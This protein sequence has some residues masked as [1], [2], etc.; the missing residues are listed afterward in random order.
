MTHGISSE[1]LKILY[2]HRTQ[3]RGAEGNHIVSIVTGIRELGHQVDILSPPGVDPFDSQSTIPADQGSGVERGWSRFWKVISSKLPAPLFEL[4]EI[5]YN[6]PAYFRLRTALRRKDYDLLYERYAT[7]L[8][9]GGLAARGAGCRLLL[10]I[11]G[12]TVV[13]DRNRAQRFSRLCRYVE[14][15]VLGKCDCAHV[16]SSYLAE[17]VVKSGFS[18]QRLVVVPN[19]FDVNRI[20]INES[21][22]SMRERFKFQDCIVVGFAGWFVP[23]DRLDLLFDVFGQLYQRNKNLRL[24]L[25]GEGE[26]ARDIMSSEKFSHLDDSIVITGAVPRSHVYDHIQMFD[27]GVLPHSNLFGSPMV[28]FEMMGLKVPIV[29]PRLPPLE[30]VL[31][32]RNTALMFDAL[33]K[34][35]LEDCISKLIEEP[36]LRQRLAHN[37][38]S[39]LQT[40]YSWKK[41]AARI[42]DSLPVA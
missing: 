26:V 13:E 16:V 9:A 11:N 8:F 10:E 5:F 35:D 37:A 6:L 39:D 14:K 4:A 34:R 41:T 42:L 15:W 2:H 25:V 24:C 3:G 7:Y 33:D 20:S 23:W 29:A 31:I 27:I 1:A 19:G 30:D 21:R 36:R 18:P 38:F 32:D 40:Q 17:S 22:D 28:M 12:L